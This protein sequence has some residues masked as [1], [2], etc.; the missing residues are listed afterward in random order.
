[1]CAAA[2]TAGRPRAG[3]LQAADAGRRGPR[4]ARSGHLHAQVRVSARGRARRQCGR[5]GPGAL[6]HAAGG[7]AQGNEAFQ[8]NSGNM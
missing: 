4:A 1:M 3:R 8:R 2:R 7:H 5:Q 6:T